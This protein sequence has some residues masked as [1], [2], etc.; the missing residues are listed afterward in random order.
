MNASD[1]TNH[2]AE[3][4]VTSRLVAEIKA[5]FPDFDP[6]GSLPEV[7]PNAL[8]AVAGRIGQRGVATL[9]VEAADL[10]RQ[11]VEA[12]QFAQVRAASL[13]RRDWCDQLA[14]ELAT[15]EAIAATACYFAELDGGALCAA[16]LSTL[17]I[18]TAAYMAACWWI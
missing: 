11:V 18:M 14:A 6:R 1:F 3:F 4:A 12:N 16:A 9:F 10:V 7:P 17:A 15:M 2:L 13:V 5:T 8:E